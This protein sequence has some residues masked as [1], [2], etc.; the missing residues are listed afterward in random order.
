MDGYQ[1]ADARGTDSRTVP[2][3][4]INRAAN[5]AVW[6]CQKRPVIFFSDASRRL[7]TCPSIH[8]FRLFMVDRIRAP[9]KSRAGKRKKGESSEAER[10]A[11]KEIDVARCP[12]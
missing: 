11:R 1:V 2:L 3:L 5:E 10:V 12:D 8:P 4:R 7:S 6:P 9:S